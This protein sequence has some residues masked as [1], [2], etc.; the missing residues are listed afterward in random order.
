METCPWGSLSADHWQ[1]F[2]FPRGHPEPPD[3]CF[4]F[5]SSHKA[6][7]WLVTPSRGR[8]GREGKGRSH[9]RVPEL[10]ALPA[11]VLGCDRRDVR[12]APLGVPL[13][14]TLFAKGHFCHKRKADPPHSVPG[15]SEIPAGLPVRRSRPHR[16]SAR[17]GPSH[18]AQR[19]N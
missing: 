2:T 18:V 7:N 1:V 13:S 19:S 15:R 3:R 9:L 6:A 11:A 17:P 8:R 14:R 4:C 12:A 16:P 5:G 10:L